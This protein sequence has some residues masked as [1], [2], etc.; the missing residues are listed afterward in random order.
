MFLT[1]FAGVPGH[2]HGLH[3]SGQVQAQDL[4][5]SDQE[6]ASPATPEQRR[7]AMNHSTMKMMGEMAAADAKLDTLVQAMNAA[8]AEEKT[9]AIAAVVT[10]LVEERHTMHK[11]MATMM[12]R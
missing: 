7:G 8:R 6:F 5:H 9:D 1:L 11:S 2:I 12:N 3:P 10:A 4:H